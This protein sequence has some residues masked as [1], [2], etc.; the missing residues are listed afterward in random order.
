MTIEIRAEAKKVGSAWGREEAENY[1]TFWGYIPKEPLLGIFPG[2]VPEELLTDDIFCEGEIEYLEIA[3]EAAR[4][5]W[6]AMRRL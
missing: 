5:T 4:A 2:I 1:K 6:T 3:E